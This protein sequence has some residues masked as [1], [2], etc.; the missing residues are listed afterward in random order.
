MAGPVAVALVAE[1]VVRVADLVA[2]A[3]KV[4]LQTVLKKEPLAV[5]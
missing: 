5:N 1:I 2:H 4:T 3:R